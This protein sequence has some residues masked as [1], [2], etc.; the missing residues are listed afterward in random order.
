MLGSCFRTLAVA[1]VSD[2][3]PR[4]IFAFVV[5]YTFPPFRQGVQVDFIEESGVQVDFIEESGIQVDFIEE[6]GIQVD[7]IEESEQPLYSAT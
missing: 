3:F 1:F 6:S 5:M 2:F 7:F 4:Y